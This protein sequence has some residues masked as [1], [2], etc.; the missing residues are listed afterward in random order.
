MENVSSKLDSIQSEL[1]QL[2]ENSTE[3]ELS[4]FADDILSLAYHNA[5]HSGQ[6][7]YIRKQNGWWNR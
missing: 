1:L 4:E 3:S 2:I 6:I 5:Y 7:I